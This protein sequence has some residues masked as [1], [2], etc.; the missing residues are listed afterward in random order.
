MI[1]YLLFIIY[2]FNQFYMPSS[3]AYFLILQ[4]QLLI[5]LSHI[6]LLEQLIISYYPCSNTLTTKNVT[7]VGFKIWNCFINVCFGTGLLDKSMLTYWKFSKF[8]KCTKTFFLESQTFFDINHWG[9]DNCNIFIL[10]TKIMTR[11]LN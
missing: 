6:Y 8:K 10:E 3:L 1:A 4:S 9:T 7:L 11:T 2:I 5:K